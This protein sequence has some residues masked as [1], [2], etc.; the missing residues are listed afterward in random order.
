M[1][2]DVQRLHSFYYRSAIGRVAQRVVRDQVITFWPEAKQQSIGGFGFAVP[3]LRPYLAEARRVVALM[4]SQ[5]GVMPWPAGMP[6]VSVLCEE[7]LW[8]IE[9]GRFD[10]LILMHGLARKSLSMEPM[11]WALER[12]GYA[13]V[14]MSYPSTRA[15]LGELARTIPSAIAECGGGRPH[16]VTHSMGGILLRVWAE[17]AP[18][19]QI[20]RVVMLGP[21]NHGSELVDEL[22]DIAVFEWLNGPAGLQ[23]GTGPEA[24]PNRLGP[25]PFELGVIAGSQSLNPIYSAMIPGPDDGKVAVPSTFVAGMDDFIV[26]P[27]THTFMMMA[28]EVI[29]Q[30]LA[31]LATGG[32]DRADAMP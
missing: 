28:P 10:K 12:A 9:N 13:T 18:P 27:V 11:A 17:S 31:F 2:L 8:P 7:T 24:L 4:P 19:D 14:N 3:L 25:A 32:F 29:E 6:N 30:T 15:P 16:V 26:L 23:L 22:G 1:H 21:P 5:Q 20:G